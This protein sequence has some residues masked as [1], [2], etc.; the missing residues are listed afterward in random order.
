ME[1]PLK[2][3]PKHLNEKDKKKQVKMLK[4]SKKLYSENKYYQRKPVKSFVP[5]LRSMYKMQKRFTM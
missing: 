3:V 2:Y 1:V 5:N 4:K